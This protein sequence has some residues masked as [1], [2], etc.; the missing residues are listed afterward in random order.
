MNLCRHAIVWAACQCGRRY[1]SGSKQ[2]RSGWQ[3]SGCSN[4]VRAQDR[5][6]CARTSTARRETP[7][8]GPRGHGR[9]RSTSWSAGVGRPGVVAVGVSGS[10]VAMAAPYAREE[11]PAHER[12]HEA[13]LVAVVRSGGRAH[14]WRPRR[15][16][17]GRRVRACRRGPARPAST[18][19]GSGPPRPARCARPSRRRRRLERRGHGDERPVEGLRVR[20]PRRRP[21][22]PPRP[23]ARGSRSA[24][25][26]GSSTFSRSGSS[27]GR[28]EELGRGHGA[29]ALGARRG[30]RRR[31][32]PRGHRRVRRVSRVRGAA[33]EDHV[34]A[35]L[36]RPPRSRPRRP[37][38]G[39]CRT[40]AGSTSSADAA[41]RC[42]R[43]VATLRIW[44][45]AASPQAGASARVGLP[46]ARRARR[47]RERRERRRSAARRPPRPRCSSRPGTDLRSTTRGGS[48]RCSLRWSR[49]SMPPALSTL[50]GF[51]ARSS[52]ACGE[53]RG[54]GQLEAI[55]VRPSSCLGERGQHAVG[56][57]GAESRTRAPVALKTALATAARVGTIG[58]SPMPA[59][60][61]LLPTLATR[62]ED[63]HRLEHVVGRKDLVRLEVGVHHRADVA[64]EDAVLEE[65]PRDALDHRADDLALGGERVHGKPA[66]VDGDH[67][68]RPARRPSRRR[69]RPRRTAC[70]RCRGG[71]SRTASC[72]PRRPRSISPGIFAAACLKAR[73]CAGCAATKILPS[74]GVQLVRL[75]PEQRRREREELRPGL[76]RREPD[77]G[78]HRVGRVAAAR[79]GALGP[80]GVADVHRDVAR[81]A[82][83][84][85]RRRR[86]PWRCGSRCRCPGRRRR[87]RRSRRDGCAPPRP[88]P[89]PR[90]ITYQLPFAMPIPRLRAWPW[91]PRPARRRPPSCCAAPSRWPWRRCRTGMRAPGSPRSCG[92]ARAGPCPSFS[93]SS[94]TADSRAKAPC[95]WP[96]ARSGAAGPGVGEDVVLLDL[97]V[98]V[99]RVERRPPARRCRRRRRSRPSRRSDGGSR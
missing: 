17:G 5:R 65:R 68:D 62:G 34:V 90:A 36:A 81:A 53:G 58:G 86:S 89:A 23:R 11:R 21:T 71:R 80:A 48:T 45:E 47:L 99:L 79:A 20:A 31:R 76:V 83:R 73:P 59:A 87:P 98:R 56:G 33:A 19:T 50:P 37:S 14:R 74:R 66:V 70:P 6:R 67:L 9:P 60:D 18:A 22:S 69:P 29:L 26:P 42:R 77:D 46:D 44:G 78:R 3:T 91:P 43:C 27:S 96:G 41:G 12:L 61:V 16:L 52:R 63:R 25:S 85:P 57:D 82:G 30:R 49:R 4:V 28:H 1:S 92:A 88:T 75:A 2:A 7:R 8:S 51:S 13:D 95:G 32:R 55:H 54:P 35:V 10:V 72:A 38:S 24:S 97:E 40:R 64:V 94:S 15:R 84:A 93:A 39:T